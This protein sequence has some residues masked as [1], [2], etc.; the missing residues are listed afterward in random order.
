MKDAR[1][2]EK[3][4]TT[5]PSDEAVDIV[6]RVLVSRFGKDALCP[7]TGDSHQLRI[8]HPALADMPGFGPYGHLSIPVY[9]GQ[10]V[11]GRYLRLVAQA[12]KQLDE[13]AEREKE[14]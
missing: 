1:L 14:E 8:K 5:T 6:R 9:K 12:V 10:R 3:W 2:I 4:L 13:A 11:R 7:N